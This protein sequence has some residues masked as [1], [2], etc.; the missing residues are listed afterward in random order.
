MS[1]EEKLMIFEMVKEG[2]IT[3]EEGDKFLGA[4]SSVKKLA[5]T[6][7]VNEETG[8]LLVWGRLQLI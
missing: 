4:L 3:P 7:Y 1:Q 5:D 2:R 8:Q 6:S